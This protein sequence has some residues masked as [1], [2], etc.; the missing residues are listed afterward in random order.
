MYANILRVLDA[1][2]C[3]LIVKFSVLETQVRILEYSSA[4]RLLLWKVNTFSF[5]MEEY[6][7]YSH[8][9]WI[10]LIVASNKRFQYLMLFIVCS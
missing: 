5:S 9:Q 7:Y 10:A 6:V 4:R 2:W 3:V 1:V 8:T